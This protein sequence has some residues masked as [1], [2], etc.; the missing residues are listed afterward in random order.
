MCNISKDTGFVWQIVSHVALRS[1]VCVATV[2]FLR[3]HDSFY[4]RKAP[5]S[6]CREEVYTRTPCSLVKG[7]V[8]LLFPSDGA[9]LTY[10]FE[11]ITRRSSVVLQFVRY[12][13]SIVLDSLVR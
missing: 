11:K 4:E 5:R 1:I 2:G 8:R 9:K 6:A 10:F 12:R 3:F 7:D 13:V